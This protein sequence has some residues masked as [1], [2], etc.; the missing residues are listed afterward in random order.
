VPTLG[1]LSGTSSV[2]Q[3]SSGPEKI[4]KKFRFVWTPFDIDFLKKQKQA[5]NSNWHWALG[6]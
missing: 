3:V 2:L 4:H 5:E 1:R 6:Q